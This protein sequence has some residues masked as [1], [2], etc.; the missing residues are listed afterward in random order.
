[1]PWNKTA[2]K[3]MLEH[4]LGMSLPEID[5]QF[6]AYMKKVAYDDYHLQWQ[7]NSM[8]GG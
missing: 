4:Y 2:V 8:P 5:Q 3:P 1:M 7:L 6:Q